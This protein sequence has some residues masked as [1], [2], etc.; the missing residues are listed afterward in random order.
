MVEILK[1]DQYAPMSVSKQV[2]IIYCGVNGY[3]DDI[4]VEACKRFEDEFLSYM[5]TRYPH[6]GKK[7]EEGGTLTG[8]LEEK[9][10][11]A[12]LEFKKGFVETL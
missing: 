4:P 6:I 10:K 8:E 2:M 12:I 3:L 11:E 5:D 1:Q 7:I 9:L